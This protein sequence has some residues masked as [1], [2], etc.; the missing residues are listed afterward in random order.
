VDATTT[1]HLTSKLSG[2]SNLLRVRCFI[3]EWTQNWKSSTIC[4]LGASYQLVCAV[5]LSSVWNIYRIQI[6]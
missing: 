1:T 3:S 5:W 4:V 6:N 2:A